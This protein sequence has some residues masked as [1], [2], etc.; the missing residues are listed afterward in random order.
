[1]GTLGDYR[2]GSAISFGPRAR[3]STTVGR[4]AAAILL[5]A[6]CLLIG[7]GAAI[8]ALSST[9]KNNGAS[10]V[11]TLTGYQEVHALGPGLHAV[12]QF[13]ESGG[14]KFTA[15]SKSEVVSPNKLAIGNIYRVYYDPKHPERTFVDGI[16]QLYQ[17]TPVYAAGSTF[18]LAG[19][20]FA[21]RPPRAAVSPAPGRRRVS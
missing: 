17:P 15:Y 6:G 18:L 5:T 7:G 2:D 20:L 16:D 8:S 13:D 12:I 3:T 11:G 1:M 14:D 21:L 10:A 19:L 4:V 9:V